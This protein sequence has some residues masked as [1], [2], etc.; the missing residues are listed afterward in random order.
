MHINWGGYAYH[1][2]EGYGRYAMHLIRQIGYLGWRVSPFKLDWLDDMPGWMLRQTGIQFD[3]LT[4]Q[5]GPGEFFV[6]LPGVSW[7]LSMTEDD[8]IPEDWV[9]RINM[10]VQRLIV[11]CEHNREAFMRC[12]VS[13]PIDV[14]PGGTDPAEFPVLPPVE[15]DTFTF[16]CLGDRGSRKGL[17]VAYM[18]FFKAFKDN[19]HV[20]LI[21]KARP[22]Q[23]LNDLKQA[24][25]TEPRIS[26]WLA[27]VPSMAD[28]YAQADCFVFPSYAEGWGMP[29]REAAMM[30]LPVIASRHTGLVAGID[31]WAIPLEKFSPQ[32][33]HLPQKGVWYVPDVNEVAEKMQ[34]VVT[35]QS[36][37]RAIGQ[38]AARWLRNNQ[39]WEHSAKKLA[40]LIRPDLAR[41]WQQQDIVRQ[42]EEE[43]P[44]KAVS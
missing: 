38:K 32:Q 24:F 22:S 7:G 35:N 8:R 28:V 26:F 29:P 3:R 6:P 19:P 11:P 1:A 21:V 31:D 5:C 23:F 25:S 41:Q 14:I 34:W 40:A 2:F 44:C 43:M 15:R 16:L 36:E 27:D 37:A 18:A 10:S 20:R 42:P 12:G 9:P 4:I 13:V 39:T 33:S 30:G 17:E